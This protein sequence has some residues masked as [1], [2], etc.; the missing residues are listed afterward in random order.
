MLDPELVKDIEKLLKDARSGYA[1]V[2]NY[3]YVKH[4]SALL[5]EVRRQERPEPVL[6]MATDDMMAQR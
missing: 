6:D 1:H 2:T 3:E 5:A 4:V